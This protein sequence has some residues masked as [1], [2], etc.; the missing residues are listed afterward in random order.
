M[1]V[2]I[3]GALGYSAFYLRQQ[4][5][6]NFQDDVFL[7][8]LSSGGSD[9]V[10]EC[11]LSRADRVEALLARIRPQ[12]IYHLAGT[13]S[14][15]YAI[16]Y[17]AN[18]L[19]AKNILDALLT[20]KLPCR[21]LL[22]GSAAEYGLVKAGGNPVAETAPLLPVRIYG[23]TKMFQTQLMNYYCL[24]HHLDLVMAR[25]FNL[26]GGG[27]RQI[28]GRLFPGRVAEQIIRVKSGLASKVKVGN[29]EAVRD[30]IDIHAAVDYYQKIMQRGK[31]GEVYNVGNGQGISMRDLL[32]RLLKDAGL[33]MSLVEASVP[34][35]PSL[36]DV[37]VIWADTTKLRGL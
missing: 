3:T 15:D 37:P 32:K 27:E 24:V 26:F 17:P 33:D 7:T 19:G 11:D 23:L 14:N 28:S 35:A 30:Y 13:V 36:V 4:L 5:S 21:V 18:V 25:T 2:L 10:S 22:I 20:L 12:Q 6:G 31:S 16:D 8:D 1:T 9:A 29:L 34:A